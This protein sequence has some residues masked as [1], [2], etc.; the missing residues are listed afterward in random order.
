MTKTQ[1]EIQQA[2]QHIVNLIEQID[3]MTR[4]QKEHLETLQESFLFY[5]NNDVYDKAL[6]T[7]KEVITFLLDEF[8]VEAGDSFIPKNAIEVFRMEV[9]DEDRARMAQI[10]EELEE[11]E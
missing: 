11:Q 6:Y 1:A 3:G 4:G 10:I 8:F 9:T 2:S 5:F 7:C